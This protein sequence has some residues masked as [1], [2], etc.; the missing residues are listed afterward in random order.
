MTAGFRPRL[1]LAV[2]VLLAGGG[3]WTMVAW[4]ANEA[5]RSQ[6]HRAVRAVVAAQA[7]YKS[8]ANG[9]FA[10]RLECLTTPVSC[11]V[12]A[13]PLLPIGE[14]LVVSR[15]ED[16]ELIVE[17]SSPGVVMAYVYLATPA[18]R[19]PWWARYSLV[20]LP[21]SVCGDHTG[22]ICTLPSGYVLAKEATACPVACAG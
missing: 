17:E 9:S 20:P 15:P 18:R 2:V 10:P 13:G 6:A 12:S 1:F 3:L 21:Y 19:A 8:A 22:R 14:D 11:G 16:R 7:R 5:E 4:G